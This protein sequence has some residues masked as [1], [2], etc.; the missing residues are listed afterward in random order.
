MYIYSS[1][2]YCRAGFKT[3][4]PGI[5]LGNYY[6][7]RNHAVPPSFYIEAEDT[8]R[9]FSACARVTQK[10]ACRYAGLL[11][12]HSSASAFPKYSAYQ[13]TR[14]SWSDG[15]PLIYNYLYMK[16]FI[17]AQNTRYLQTRRTIL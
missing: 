11:P 12:V 10:T 1:Q 3:Q 2:I 15:V 17:H 6:R 14:R 8:L 13:Y 5:F 16:V 7:N 9:Y 4:N